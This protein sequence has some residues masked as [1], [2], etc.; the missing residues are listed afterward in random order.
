M[1]Q[2][3]PRDTEYRHTVMT[4]A[5]TSLL[6]EGEGLGLRPPQHVLEIHVLGQ[7]LEIRHVLV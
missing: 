3:W 1:G 4:M 2:G 7:V 6:V 5:R